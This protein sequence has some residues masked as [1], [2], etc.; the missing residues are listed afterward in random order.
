[1]HV[2]AQELKKR[3][4]TVATL[5]AAIL[6]MPWYL[7]QMNYYLYDRQERVLRSQGQSTQSTIEELKRLQLEK[8]KLWQLLAVKPRELLDMEEMLRGSIHV[9]AEPF[10]NSSCV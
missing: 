7:H 1:M 2:R 4:S 5:R 3:T 10:A 6:H 8:E 9:R